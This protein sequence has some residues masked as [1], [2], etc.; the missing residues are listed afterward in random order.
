[1]SANDSKLLAIQEKV[2]KFKATD[3]SLLT[4]RIAVL[5]A[6][7]KNQAHLIDQIDKSISA[8]ETNLSEFAE[9]EF[10]KVYRILNDNPL[11]R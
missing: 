7:M 3:V 11:G 6:D 8:V 2:K 4:E 10:A 9:K 5:E 1:M